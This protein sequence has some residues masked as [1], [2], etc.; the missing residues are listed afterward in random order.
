MNCKE[1]III[2]GHKH[3]LSTHCSRATEHLALK[4]YFFFFIISNLIYYIVHILNMCQIL[5]LY[6]TSILKRTFI[7]PPRVT[8]SA[9][10]KA[11]EV[12]SHNISHGWHST[13]FKVYK[14]YSMINRWLNWKCKF[15]LHMF[16]FIRFCY[17]CV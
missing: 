9:T 11:L 17:N 6:N 8:N 16:Y 4:A 3:M 5:H 12:W 2:S 7:C 15:C 1:V 14:S 13:K 10:V